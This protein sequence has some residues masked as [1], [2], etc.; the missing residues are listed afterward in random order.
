MTAHQ[1]ILNYVFTGLDVCAIVLTILYLVR[2]LIAP[3]GQFESQSIRR[4]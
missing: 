1:L 3:V 4:S 2:L